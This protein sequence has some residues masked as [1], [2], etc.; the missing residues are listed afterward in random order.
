MTEDQKRDEEIVLPLEDLKAMF[1]MATSSMDFGSGFLD[2]DEVVLLRKIAV[3]LGVDPI[4]GTPYDHKPNYPHVESACG[5]RCRD[6]VAAHVSAEEY[7]AY[8]DAQKS[9]LLGGGTPEPTDG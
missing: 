4:E 8:L 2:T 9:Y 1:D 7:A 6:R 5:W 3:R